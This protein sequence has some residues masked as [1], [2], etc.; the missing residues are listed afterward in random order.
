MTTP[1]VNTLQELADS[2]DIEMDCLGGWLRGVSQ[3]CVGPLAEA[4]LERMSLTGCSSAPT[5]SPLR[6][7]SAKPTTHRLGLRSSWPGGALPFIVLADSSKLGLRPFRAWARLALTWT[8]VTDGAD[9]AQPQK[10]RDAGVEVE[11][12]AVSGY[13]RWVRCFWRLSQS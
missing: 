10:F 6:T 8:L 4:A 3:S 5:L 13:A 12:A 7:A 9:P 2:E 11:V 1:G